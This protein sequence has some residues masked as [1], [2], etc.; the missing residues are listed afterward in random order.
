MVATLKRGSTR[1]DGKVFIRYAR[2]YKNGEYWSTP[3]VLAKVLDLEKRRTSGVGRGRGKRIDARTPEY[4][5]WYNLQW[6][7][8]R[9][10]NDPV[11]REAKLRRTELYH[12]LKERSLSPRME[13]LLGCDITTLVRH[14]ETQFTEGM[15]W[16]T[17][18]RWGWHL[19]HRRALA[20]AESVEEV[21]QLFHFTNLQPLWAPANLSKYS[22]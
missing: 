21:H 1:P 8:D 13:R 3:E 2:N 6:K 20:T 7:L 15:T 14:L 10:K 9:A 18:G 17:W 5:R 4:Q 19:D 11:F 22:K 12:N 16:D